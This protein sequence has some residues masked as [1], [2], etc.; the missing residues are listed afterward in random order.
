[1]SK[2]SRANI[3]YDLN[4]SPH[5]FS[6]G[7]PEFDTSIRFV[8]SSNLY[9]SNFES[10]YQENREKINQSLS[11]RFGFHI[12]N[13]IIADLK[14]Y[15]SIEK[16]GFLIYKDGEKFECLKD[17]TLDGSKLIVKS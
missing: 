4:V 12:K 13:N 7:Y 16:R 8:F 15:I 5:T 6:L 1:M 9:R 11:N 14:L 2:L 3:A 17:I 10:R